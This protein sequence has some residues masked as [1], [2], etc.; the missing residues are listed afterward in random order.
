MS[1]LVAAV[2]LLRPLNLLLGALAVLITAALMPGWPP[3]GALLWAIAVVA[4]YNGAA[5]SLNDWFDYPIDRVNRPHRPL[6]SGALP[7]KAGWLL[8]VILFVAGALAAMQLPPAAQYIAI[9]I[10]LPLLVLY[11]PLLKGL[12]FAG[13]LVV[14][15]IL[16]LTFLFSGAAFG[17]LGIM[18]VPAGLAFGFNLLREVVKDVEDLAGDTREGVGTFAVRFGVPASI[19]MI[20][21]LTIFLMLACLLPYILAIYG[22]TYL[23]AL[24][25]GVEFPLLY[26]LIYLFKHPNPEGCSWVAKVLKVDIFFGLLAVYVS[27]FNI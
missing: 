15:A 24:I 26:T 19:K 9:F 5:N 25:I 27:K 12:P 21:G 3:R 1:S 14:A 11:T 23:A 7:R 13:N 4:S 10:A 20:F 8:A 16:G 17:H 6:A 22:A 2:K 18:W